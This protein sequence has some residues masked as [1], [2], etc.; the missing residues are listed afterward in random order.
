MES[1]VASKKI[2]LP[3]LAWIV[4][5]AA[6]L[7]ALLPLPY[8]FYTLL[9]LIVCGVAIL[10][11]YQEYLTFNSVTS[12]AVFFS[13]TALLFNPVFPIHLTREVWA[14]LDFVSAVALVAHW[15]CR[16]RRGKEH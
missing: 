1:S 6:L 9:R 15:R 14:P 7:L 16:G 10:L 3:A 2:G 12:W 13:V 11:C 4:P 5:A 8:G